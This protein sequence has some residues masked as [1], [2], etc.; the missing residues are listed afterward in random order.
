MRDRSRLSKVGYGTAGGPGRTGCAGGRVAVAHALPAAGISS[1]L[2]FFLPL[3][4]TPAPLHPPTQPCIC[5][6]SQVAWQYIVIDEAQ[7]MKDR[8]SKL[9][10]DLDKF[11]AARRLLLSGTPLQNGVQAGMGRGGLGGVG[12][13]REVG[14]GAARPVLARRSGSPVAPRS[15]TPASPPFPSPHPHHLPPHADLQELW[16]LLNLLLPE[17]FDDKKMFAEWF[18]S[19]RTD[20]GACGRRR[21]LSG[22]C[23]A[24]PRAAARQAPCPAFRVEE[25]IAGRGHVRPAGCPTARVLTCRA[26][27]ASSA[28]P[29]T[30]SGR[31]RGGL[32]GDREA[33]GGHPPPASDPGALHAAAPGA[34]GAGVGAWVGG[35]C[36][37]APGQRP[38]AP[39]CPASVC[40]TSLA[41]PS[42]HPRAAPVLPA[43]PSE[44]ANRTPRTHTHRTHSLTHPSTPTPGGGCGEQAAAQG[45]CGGQGSHEPLPVLHLPVGQGQRHHPAR[46]HRPLPGQVPPGVCLPQQQVHGAAQG[47]RAGGWWHPC[48]CVR[49]GTGRERSAAQG[50]VHLHA[51]RGSSPHQCTHPA[52][53]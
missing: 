14:T 40:C 11:T 18:G 48:L 43:R 38:A 29:P 37:G 10:R 19:H 8:Q 16:S 9:A 7:R 45:A 1:T 39:L 17:V 22:T 35:V 30:C 52:V 53:H 23:G 21:P 28:C 50:S 36:A 4:T 25:C 24:V 47:G 44:T 2:F 42:S 49:V 46:P 6:P 31:W 27:H 34:G 26:R 3:C 33:G 5:P 32:A 20:P 12:V 13:G 51:R 41:H 15:I